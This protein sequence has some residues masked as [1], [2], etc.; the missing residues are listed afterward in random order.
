MIGYLK[1]NVTKIN[2]KISPEAPPQMTMLLRLW[3]KFRQPSFDQFQRPQYASPPL[4]ED[5]LEEGQEAGEGGELGE[6]TG[7]RSRVRGRGRCG[8]VDLPPINRRPPR[9]PKH[10]KRSFYRR[11][12]IIFWAYAPPAGN[13]KPNIQK[14]GNLPSSRGGTP[15][16]QHIHSK[17][18]GQLH[19]SR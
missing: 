7:A 1:C 16:S 19:I 5:D 9:H 2:P 4:P 10:G 17:N 12:G 11:G 13:T 14:P 15:L 3:K 8:G 18:G 6:E